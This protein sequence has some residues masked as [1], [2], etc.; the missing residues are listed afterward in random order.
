[1]KQQ[2]VPDRGLVLVYY[3]DGKGKTTAALGAVLRAVGQ[4][5]KCAVLQF[6]KGEWPSSERIAIPRHM[7]QLVSIEAAGKGFVGIQGDKKPKEEHEKAAR[8]ALSRAQEL[9]GND[10][11]FILV[12]DEILDA[13]ALGLLSEDD[14]VDL[15]KQRTQQLHLILTGHEKLRRIIELADVATEMRKEKHSYDNG[16]LAVQGLDY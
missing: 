9:A 15:I 5:K 2:A 1:M 4:N 14:V 13:V 16:L 11:L 3:G 10:D 12:I 8:H 6:I 7:N